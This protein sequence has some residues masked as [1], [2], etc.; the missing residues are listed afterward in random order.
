MVFVVLSLGL[1]TLD[2][3][4]GHLDRIRSVLEVAVAPIQY[5]V[6]LPFAASDWASDSLATRE[7]LL[8]ENRRLHQAQLL[9]RARSSA[10]PAA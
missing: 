10:I 5:A 8:E 3:R 1:M 2:H 6:N 4:F 9:A 7:T